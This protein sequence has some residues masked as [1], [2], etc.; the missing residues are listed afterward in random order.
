MMSAIRW[1]ALVEVVGLVTA[2]NAVAH[3]P[4]APEQSVHAAPGAERF[5]PESFYGTIVPG[6]LTTSAGATKF[7]VE[8]PK[9]VGLEIDTSQKETVIC[10]LEGVPS[11]Q[12]ALVTSSQGT[13]PQPAASPAPG[14]GVTSGAGGTPGQTL[15]YYGTYDPALNVF[16]VSNVGTN[17]ESI[18]PLMAP[19][20]SS[21]DDDDD[22]DD[23]DDNENSS[24]DDDDSGDDDDD[25]DD[26][27]D[28]DDD[29][30][31]EDGDDDDDD[32]E[33]DD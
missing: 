15:Y 17:A 2:V 19:V 21:S 9:K 7:V 5:G 18:A 23:E 4:W 12:A 16:F 33:D 24:D 29:D 25:D 26:D 14:P 32:E 8:R 30:D 27:E 13:V 20:A 3:T 11:E 10:Q 22:D 28:D 1:I 31:D 6:S